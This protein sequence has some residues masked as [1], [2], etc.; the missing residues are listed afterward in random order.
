MEAMW[1]V[2]RLGWEWLDRNAHARGFLFSVT[3]SLGCIGPSRTQP[4][5]QLG[6]S[7]HL[8]C[9]SK[10]V[11]VFCI[12]RATVWASSPRGR[13]ARL[14][15]S[16]AQTRLRQHCC[17][18]AALALLM[19]RRR[20]GDEDGGEARGAPWSAARL[21]SFCPFLCCAAQRPPTAPSIAAEGHKGLPG[22]VE[23]TSAASSRNDRPSVSPSKSKSSASNS[24]AGRDAAR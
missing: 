1:D 19:V 20:G 17:R 15:P 18:R 16:A 2:V 10:A 6:S 9:A 13:R 21:V 12:R 14:S 7:P 8:H 11:G 5:A 24:A 4:T 3:C 23:G 22:T